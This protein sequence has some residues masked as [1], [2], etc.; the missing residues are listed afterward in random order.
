M[1]TIVNGRPIEDMPAAERDA[2]EQRAKNR[3]EEMLAARRAPAI[4]TD[5]TFFANVNAAPALH[6]RPGVA[7]E[8]RRVAL[9]GGVNPVGKTYMPAIAAFPGDPEAWV[10]GR[11]DIQRVCEARGWACDG[12]VKVDARPAEGAAPPPAIA[13]DILAGLAERQRAADPSLSRAE[14]TEAA[15]DLHAPS[16]SQP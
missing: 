4:H 16:W 9:A 8:Y 10:S 13:P 7:E 5:A 11:G 2:F 6:D 15:I 14:A 12:A 1:K 3:L